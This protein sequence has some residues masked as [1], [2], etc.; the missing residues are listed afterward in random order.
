MINNAK[1]LEILNSPIRTIE[2]EV[3]VLR[4]VSTYAT[5]TANDKLKSFTIERLGESGKFFGFGITHKLTVNI[6]DTNR[7]VNLDD[8]AIYL[9]TPYYVANGSRVSPYPMDFEIESIT[10]DE[11]TNELTI[12]AYDAL[13]KATQHTVSEALTDNAQYITLR[14][15]ASGCASTIA[16][17]D[18][19]T[20]DNIPF[21]VFDSSSHFN[22]TK[23]NF[24]GTETIR[25]VLNAIA[26]IT[27]TVYYINAN[28]ELMFFRLNKDSEPV[29]T[30]DKS[31]YFTMSSEKPKTLQEV[32]S[33][34]ELGNNI[35]A[36]TGV[37]GDTQYIRDNPFWEL[38]NKVD[39]YLTE[40]IE[41]VGGL[42]ITP[43]ECDWRGNYL[44]EIGDKIALQTKDN[45]IITSYVL[46][47]VVTYNG[48]LSEQTSWSYGESEA[49]TPSNPVTLGAALKQTYA[50]VDK[51]NQ[52]I[53][54]IASETTALKLDTN[55]IAASVSGIQDALD[56][57]ESDVDELTSRVNATMTKDEVKIEIEKMSSNVNS[58][59]TLTGFTFD[60]NGMKV[61]K[62]GSELT[63]EITEDGMKVYKDIDTVLVANNNGVNAKN[64]HATTYLLVGKN[65][66]FEDYENGRTACF[67]YGGD[68]INVDIW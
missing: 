47:D 62:S 1:A 16:V 68:D 4:G 49:E 25:D 2:A 39:V 32:V 19:V 9:L 18:V 20:S 11:N 8:G 10:R 40:A 56:G 51:A 59:T 48:A 12:T 35:S 43:F 45:G 31:K 17:S 13:Y 58:V 37:D 15:F 3:E 29:L 14:D 38:S 61:S 57:V 23:L 34:T 27:Q 67:W 33:A 5:W 28:Y 50:K 30:I 21:N 52:Q 6:I 46:N 66:R 63:T 42:A 54:L 44:L 26:E 7:E 53:E 65:I 60:E 24:E 64:L 36:S 22:Q 55:G 41:A